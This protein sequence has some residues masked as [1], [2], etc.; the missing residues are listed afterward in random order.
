MKECVAN[1]AHLARRHDGCQ[2]PRTARGRTIATG[3]WGT[4]TVRTGFLVSALAVLGVTCG[5][6]DHDAIECGPG[7]VLRDGLCR[8]DSGDGD[9][10]GDGDSDADAD[11]DADGDVDCSDQDEDGHADATCGGDDCDDLD[12]A[13]HPGAPDRAGDCIDQNCDI[14]GGADEDVDDHASVACGGDDCD[15]ENFDA[16]PGAA[17]N[18]EDGVDQNCDDIDGVDADG[19][20]FAS[21]ASGGNDC[22]DASMTT[23]PGSPDSVGNERDDNCDGIDGVDADADGLASRES[24]G[25]DCDDGN[26]EFGVRCPTC[27]PCIDDGDNSECG[28]GRCITFS[29]GHYCGDDCAVRGC[30]AWAEC[31]SFSQGKLHLCVPYND[32]P[33]EQYNRCLDDCDP[34][35]DECM[36]GSCG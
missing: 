35:T 21:E 10:D 16:Y 24:G 29:D 11:A 20:G 36:D 33:C 13:I 19:D 8:P 14:V 15:D 9:A 4:M 32:M 31:R 28:S 6:N 25:E 26:A 17:D 2:A 30:G 22:D 1:G 18:A 3:G 5:D 23:F 34:A 27:L 7:T 12:A